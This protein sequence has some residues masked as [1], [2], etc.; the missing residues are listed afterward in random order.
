MLD[1][2]R[3]LRKYNDSA[4]FLQKSIVF[5]T[6]SAFSAHLA[7]LV[8]PS[9]P[10]E[11]PARPGSSQLDLVAPSSPLELPARPGSSSFNSYSKWMKILSGAS[12]HPN[13]YSLF[14]SYSKLMKILSGASI[15]PNT[16][17]LFNSYLKLMKILSGA[18]LLLQYIY[19]YSIPIQN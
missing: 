14:N 2:Y 7:S 1:S 13:T 19:P 12:F 15:H 5:H 10:W 6:F 11:V 8:A 17:S 3:N 9:S 16:Y 4:S 18:S